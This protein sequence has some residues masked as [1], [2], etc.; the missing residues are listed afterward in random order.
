MN[1]AVILAGGLGTRL[2]SRLHG[3]PKPLIEI[4]DKPLLQHQLEWLARNNFRNVILLVSYQADAIANFISAADFSNLCIELIEDRIP[5][6]TAGAVL[7]AFEHLEDQFLVVY[8]DTMLDVDL[9][10]F[11]SFHDRHQDAAVSI[12]VHPNDHPRDSDLVEVNQDGRVLRIWPYPHQENALL[13]NLVNAALY[14]AR[15][16]H[17]KEFINNPPD[18]ILDFGKHVFPQ[19]LSQSKDIYAYRSPEYIKDCGTPERVD[20]VTADYFSGVISASCLKNKQAAIFLDRDGTINIENGYITSPEQL[21]LLPGAATA[22]KQL[23]NSGWCVFVVTNQPVIAR[24]E[25]STEQLRAIHYRLDQLLA[26]HGAYIDDLVYCP[27]HPDS[28]FR[29][30]VSAL[31]LNCLCRKPGTLMIDQLIEKY[32]IDRSLSWFIGDTTVDIETAHRSHLKSICVRTG[33]AGQDG[34]FQVS[35]T[36]WADSLADAAV[37]LCQNPYAP[38]SL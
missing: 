8:G 21:D 36:R 1:Q 14:I 25:A 22:I 5:R 9:D 15:K 18:Q 20:K 11:I 24:G 27:H 2:T 29:G 26:Q 28:G 17:L 19:L 32:H 37:Y 38:I 16:A 34:R 6:G 31:K 12:F 10:R 35:P 3:R 4:G 30:E 23:T 33:Q 7:A 13:P